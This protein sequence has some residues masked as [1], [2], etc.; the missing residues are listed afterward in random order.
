MKASA[1][2]FG[3]GSRAA[4]V[5]QQAVVR[6]A[7]AA[8]LEAVLKAAA[9][10]PDAGNRAVVAAFVAAW[11]GPA[12]LRDSGDDAQVREAGARLVAAG[13]AILQAAAADAEDEL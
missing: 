11:P 1:H 7:A 2:L 9:A 13:G 12:A 3:A 10:A 8:A 6:R 5:S 4:S